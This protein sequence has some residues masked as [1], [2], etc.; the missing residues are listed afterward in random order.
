MRRPTARRLASLTAF[1][2]L[3]LAACQGEAVALLDDPNDILAAAATSTAA[4]TSV[5]AELAVAGIITADA[6]G[7]G[8]VPA[9]DLRDTSLIADLDLRTSHGRFAFSAP[10][11][12]GI[13]GEV[14]TTAE[15]SYFK[16]S[17]TGTKYQ[18]TP[19]DA[20][21]PAPEN[22]LK[23]L[24]DLIARRDLDPVKGADVPC[25]GGTCYTLTVQLTAEELAAIG[26][27][28]APGDLVGLPVPEVA[29]ASMDLIIHVEQTTG[30]LS[31]INAKAALGD[32]GELTVTATFTHWNEDF[33]IRVPP[34]E[35]V[36]R[37]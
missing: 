33:Q 8:G 22:P 11:L 7:G 15:G 36:E 13:N 32:L 14:I 3:V 27:G 9:V 16:T 19:N 20:M 10:G 2:A 25:A 23:G 5:R 30:R 28:V 34:P 17:M 12:M 24:V 37:F 26:G 35:L 4:A 1:L 6:F 21:V 31:D 18:F 29:G